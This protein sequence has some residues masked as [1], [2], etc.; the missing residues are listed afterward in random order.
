MAKRNN[1]APP[2]ECSSEFADQTK[3]DQS[4]VEWYERERWHVTSAATPL[5]ARGLREPGSGNRLYVHKALDYV[6]EILHDAIVRSN[7]RISPR[8]F[9]QLEIAM[10]SA[11]FARIEE[12]E[13]KSIP[14]DCDEWSADLF[15]RACLGVATPWELLALLA[16]FPDH[17]RSLELAKQTHPIDWLATDDMDIEI[18]ALL[19]DTGAVIRETERTQKIRYSLTRV[20]DVINPQVATFVRKAEKGIV[21]L[22]DGGFLTIMQRDCL[23]MDMTHDDTAII[24]THMRQWL[25]TQGAREQIRGS[26]KV[27]YSDDT[28]R[29]FVSG[30]LATQET[31]RSPTLVPA[32]RSYYAHYTPSETA[33]AA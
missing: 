5:N 19:S 24:G 30:Q 28:L 10:Q 21:P 23:V 13:Q 12:N 6:G 3:D 11:L 33:K 8:M 26:K 29:E 7:D 31:L 20:D 4:S 25:A 27:P 15:Q 18:E 2:R 1:Y 16:T 22:D 14:P 32:V 9:G 17:L